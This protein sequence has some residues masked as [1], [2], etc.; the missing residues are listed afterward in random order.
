MT[1]P[2]VVVARELLP[3]GANRLAARF[4]VVC[5]G[6]DSTHDDLLEMVPG[7]S[8][9]VADPTVRVDEA[10]LD[11]AGAGLRLVANFAVGHDN[12]DLE[13]CARRGVPVSNTPDVLTDATAELAL[14]LTLA[15]ARQLPAAERSL[16][17]GEWTGWDPGAYRG[18]QLSGCSFGIVGMG[19]IGLRY[20]EL[21]S[22]LAGAVF[23]F[24]RSRN[25]P[26]EA[27]LGARRVEL[28]VLLAESDV[29]S[30]HLPAGPDSL[31][32]IDS[33]ALATMRHGAVLVN[34]A[35]G[36]LVDSSALARSLSDGHLG[37]AGLDVVEGEPAV[38][39][40]LLAAP[41]VVVTPHIGS[42]TFTAR[43]RMAEMVAENVIS[44]MDGG[45]P[46]TPVT[47]A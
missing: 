34:T 9:I 24:S 38:P 10:V 44:V 8:A 45:D 36:S 43:D 29:V 4:E 6:L 35:R 46:V 26:A 16:R 3:A 27:R 19:R 47:L 25:E 28:D 41:R 14:G 23:Y 17:R 18:R 15:A 1:A 11:A 13:A 37:A 5:G 21:V 31:H 2:R 42:A 20:A 33:G 32:L 12:V 7:A 39:S 30:L 22:P 40:E